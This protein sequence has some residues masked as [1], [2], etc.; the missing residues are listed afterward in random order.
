MHSV[1]VIWIRAG[2]TVPTNKRLVLITIARDWDVS[3]GQYHDGQWTCHGDVVQVAYWADFPDA[4]PPP[5]Y[6]D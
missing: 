6:Q 4:P 5:H 3:V 2:E 1:V